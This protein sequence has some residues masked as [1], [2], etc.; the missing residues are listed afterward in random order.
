MT[1]ILGGGNSTFLNEPVQVLTNDSRG[2]SIR[3]EQICLIKSMLR[4]P[5]CRSFGVA[6]PPTYEVLINI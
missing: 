3:L 1:L 4:A 5:R 6:P 2:S